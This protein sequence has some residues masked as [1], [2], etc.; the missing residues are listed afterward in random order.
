M[1]DAETSANIIFNQEERVSLRK[2]LNQAKE[3]L[4]FI[5]N[6]LKCKEEAIRT[7]IASIVPTEFRITLHAAL[8]VMENGGRFCISSIPCAFPPGNNLNFRVHEAGIGRSVIIQYTREDEA[9]LRFLSS[10]KEPVDDLLK[11]AKTLI[12]NIELL[13][14]PLQCA[15]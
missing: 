10:Q 1:K 2:A 8:P 4:G 7:A 6:T 15:I 9:Q 11:Q 14:A 13:S 12:D 5:L 3:S